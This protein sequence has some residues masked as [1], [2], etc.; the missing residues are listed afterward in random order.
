MGPQR[1]HTERTRYTVLCIHLTCFVLSRMLL[2]INGLS[3]QTHICTHSCEHVYVKI[4]KHTSM[5]VLRSSNIPHAHR[6]TQIS[7]SVVVTAWGRL[8]VRWTQ[9]EPAPNIN[10]ISLS[11]LPGPLSPSSYPHFLFLKSLPVPPFRF[12]SIFQVR[13]NTQSISVNRKGYYAFCSSR[14]PHINIVLETPEV[15]PWSTLAGAVQ[16]YGNTVTVTSKWLSKDFRSYFIRWCLR[17][18]LGQ[19]CLFCSHLVVSATVHSF[20]L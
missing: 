20:H 11:S 16:L 12:P 13:G 6:H 9:S 19:N 14:Y 7:S 5:D 8:M 3:V 4:K 15:M 2:L 1:A 10:N 17:S 18:F